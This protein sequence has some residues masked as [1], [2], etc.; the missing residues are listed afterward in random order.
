MEANDRGS[1]L[2]RFIRFRLHN[3]Q[4]TDLLP[5]LL[6]N[7]TKFTKYSLN[8][9]INS[10]SGTSLINYKNMITLMQENKKP[11]ELTGKSKFETNFLSTD[12]YWN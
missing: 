2:R 5:I 9:F 4:H 6:F 8:I 1:N 3:A 12:E 10:H 7:K 11:I